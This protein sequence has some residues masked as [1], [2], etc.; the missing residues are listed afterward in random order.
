[1]FS[2]PAAS[3]YHSN[4]YSAEAVCEHCGGV[5]RHE[6]WCITRDALVQYAYG[7]VLDSGKMTLSDRLILH[8]LGV[9]WQNNNSQC[10]AEIP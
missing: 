5:I 8:A 4:Q 7:V 9:S 1:M 6:R 2:K 10:I 3:W